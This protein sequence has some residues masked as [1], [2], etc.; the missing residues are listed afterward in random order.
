MAVVRFCKGG[1]DTFVT[2]RYASGYCKE[3]AKEYSAR[4][5]ADPIWRARR[6][7][8]ISAYHKAN[9]ERSAARTR[10]WKAK[11]PEAARASQRQTDLKR[12]A[13]KR[14]SDKVRHASPAGREAARRVL[15]RKR[16]TP[17]GKIE[18]ALR[19]R[20]RAA[21]KGRSKAASGPILV[22]CSMEELRRHLE[23]LWQPGMSWD[24]YGL[25]GWVIDHILPCASF[26]LTDPEQQYK[27]FHYTNL[28]PLWS[29]DNMTKGARIV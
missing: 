7:A 14:L 13:K 17:Q 21:L 1:H 16:A 4:R 11:N 24:N 20:L 12:K 23:A 10:R 9:R 26:D 18:N 3:C 6:N 15:A 25:K 8:Q 28:Q 29:V 22:G 2:G 27:C 5:Y 19:C